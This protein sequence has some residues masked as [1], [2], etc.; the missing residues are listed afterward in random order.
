MDRNILV[1]EDHEGFRKSLCQLLRDEGYQVV[2]AVDGGAA[3]NELNKSQFDL[4][5][6][7]LKMPRADGYDLLRYAVGAYPQLP[8][9]LISGFGDEQTRRN[10]ILQGA[11]DYIFKPVLFDDLL[12]KIKTALN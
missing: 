6:S 2:E 4:L 9:I 5:L 1:V 12:L 10:A 3:I 8:V 11:R 7:N